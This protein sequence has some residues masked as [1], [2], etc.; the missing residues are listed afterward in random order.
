M[1]QQ[2]LAA[3]LGV[4]LAAPLAAL[5][6]QSLRTPD[7]AD[8]GAAVPPIVYESAFSRPAAA[9]QDGQ[10]TPDK[11][12][13]AA[14]DAVASGPAGHGAHQ[15]PGGGHAHAGPA[16]A[17]GTPVPAPGARQPAPVDHSKHH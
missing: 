9:P 7:P 14:N 17:H 16:A 8:P 2:L 4:L 13:R 5:A 10:P 3:I 6:Q 12:W 15:A 1:H 11:A